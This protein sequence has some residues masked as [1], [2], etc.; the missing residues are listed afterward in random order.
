MVPT[1]SRQTSSLSPDSSSSD[2]DTNSILDEEETIRRQSER[3]N[4]PPYIARRGARSS[5]TGARKQG[6]RRTNRLGSA[7]VAATL[8]GPAAVFIGGRQ[9]WSKMKKCIREHV[10]SARTL[11]KS[12]PAHKTELV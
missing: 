1:P 5:H 2:S 4:S 8:L 3:S 12:L 11:S 10:A 7:S 6:R 9:E